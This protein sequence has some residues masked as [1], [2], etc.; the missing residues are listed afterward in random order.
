MILSSMSKL[1]ALSILLLLHM[2]A[3]QT[4]AD[5]MIVAHRG[6]SQ[7]APE[8]T[9]PAFKLAWLQGADAIEGDF[10]LTADGRI[11]CIHD[12]DTK[13]V[14]DRRLVVA[15][16]SLAALQELDVG[17][18]FKERWI[19]TR[20][21]TLE[22]VMETV[23]EGKQIFIEIKCGPEIVPVLVKEL[24]KSALKQS[25]IVVISFKGAVI[26]ALKEKRPGIKAFWLTDLE[27]D[28]TGGFAPHVK[29]V[30]ATLERIKADGI[31]TAA[32]EFLT[33]DYIKAIRDAGYEYHVWTVDD[34][35]WA[36][37]LI[38][39]GAQSITTNVP[40]EMIR[41]LEEKES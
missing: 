11:V 27:R 29:D 1:S 30:L 21:P 4:L 3:S 33:A 24:D 20:I 6:A 7:D 10:H 35:E 28:L 16:S 5:P 9:V 26:A 18:W 13:K 39:I 22:Q 36:A 40:G 34:P 38:E 2:H 12:P 37:E 23:P 17:A 41:G 32:P 15:E 14:N 31:S 25:Q 8:N 19:G